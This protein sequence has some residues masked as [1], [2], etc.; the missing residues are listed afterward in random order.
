MKISVE[1][2]GE[3]LMTLCQMHRYKC[4]TDTANFHFDDCMGLPCKDDCPIKAMSS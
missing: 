1:Q 2:Y 3:I 4:G